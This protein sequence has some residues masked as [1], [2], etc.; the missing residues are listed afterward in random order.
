MLRVR[1]D[2]GIGGRRLAWI[3]SPTGADEAFVDA[4]AVALLDR[5]LVAAGSTAVEP[6]EAG[7]LPICDRD[8]LL[9]ALH[10]N[11]FGDRIDADVPCQACGKPYSLSLGLASLIDSRRP[12]RPEGIDGPDEAGLFRMGEITFR[13]PSTE[14][15][16]AAAPVGPE[17]R[18][19]L[20]AA[21]TLS[22]ETTGH[23]DAVESAMAALGPTLDLELDAAC[24]ACGAAQ[25][26][27][28]AIADF[29]IRTLAAERPFLLREVHRIARA[30]GW[31]HES[32][33]ALPR[34]DRQAFVTLIGESVPRSP[35]AVARRAFG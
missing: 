35:A 14:D 27:R 6:G 23:E 30:Y 31:S 17:A 21:C 26:P 13:L 32:I 19:H 33:M 25:R 28:F 34:T 29:L 1:L 5:C 9:A 3:R 7:R 16:E 15:V 18:S 2:P 24:P 8:R 10:R 11:L 4:G 20:L 12:E 22:G